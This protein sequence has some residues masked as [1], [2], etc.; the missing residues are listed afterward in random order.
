MDKKK[1]NFNNNEIVDILKNIRIILFVMVA[2]LLVNAGAVINLNSSIMKLKDNLGS[3]VE[4]QEEI[5]EYD[6]SEFKEVN[7]KEFKKIMSSKGTNVVYIGRATCGYCAMFIPVMVEAQEKYGFKTN[8]FDI[9]SI[10]DFEK[11]SVIDQNAYDELST[12]NDFF[13]ENFLATPMVVI[14][15][16]G[17]YVDGTLGYQ[18]IASYSQFLENNNFKE[19]K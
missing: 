16:D 5:P 7:Y 13:E 9:S 6:V 10:F 17:K 18:E 15:K 3:P 4:E 19:S 11:N 12:L 8:Y 14:F 1:I 2:I